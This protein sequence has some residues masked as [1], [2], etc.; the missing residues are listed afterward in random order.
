[1]TTFHRLAPY[2]FVRLRTEIYLGSREPTT[3]SL[4]YYDG[5]KLSVKDFTFVPALFTYFREMLDNALD[6]VVGRKHGKSV[7]VEYI[8]STMEFTV[9]DDGNGIPIVHDAKL[10]GIPAE[11]L[12]SEVQAGSNFDEAEMKRLGLN[13]GSAKP[14][15]GRG[16]WAGANG[17]GGS[18]VNFTSEDFRVDVWRDGKH[19]S[20]S[21]SEGTDAIKTKGPK[22]TAGSQSRRGTRVQFRPSKKVFKTLQLPEE[23]IRSH[24]WMVAA[25]NRD[26]LTVSFQGERLTLK[27]TADPVQTLFFAGNKVIAVP[28]TGEKF[29]AVY[30]VVTDFMDGKETNYSLVN[31]VPAFNGGT[32]I[33]PFRD[34]FYSAM[35]AGLEKKAEKEKLKLS[36]DDVTRNVLLFNIT[37]MDAPDF[38]AQSKSKLQN[39]RIEPIIKAGITDELIAK[40]IRNNPDWVESILDRCRLRD[41]ASVR[42]RQNSMKRERVAKLQDATS[43]HRQSCVLFMGEGDSAVKGG[44]VTKRDPKIHGILPLRGKVENAMKLNARGAVESAVYSDIMKAIGLQVGVKAERADLRYGKIYIA[45]DEDEDGKHITALLVN[46]FYRFWPELFDPALPPFIFKFCTPFIIARKAGKVKYFYAHDYVEYEKNTAKYSGWD[47]TRA[48][49]L[50]SLQLVDWVHALTTPCLVPIISDKEFA[51]TLDLLFNPKR[52]KDRQK[53]LS[54]DE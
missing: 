49:G 17:V 10:G 29:N 3:Q 28:I 46:F 41:T 27:N 40:I 14:G 7:K 32:H 42:R 44:L 8:E 9:E 6:E 36:R 20:Q 37:K 21:W 16:E 39:K 52:S 15:R 11:I 35:V 47:I 53:W 4:V 19:F 51:E 54:N 1:M 18:V 43:S 23:L 34:A 22:I 31:N 12:L 13:I 24:L 5:S 30:Y 26:R 33:D 45:T 38:D 25:A 50:G 2:P 48:K